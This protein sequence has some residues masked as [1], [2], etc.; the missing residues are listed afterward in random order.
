[1]IEYKE[2]VANLDKEKVDLLAYRVTTQ[3]H[4]TSCTTKEFSRA[5]PKL[6]FKNDEIK[7]LKEILTEKETKIHSLNEV[8]ASKETTIIE[9]ENPKKEVEVKYSKARSRTVGK[10]LHTREKHILW[11]K[12]SVEVTKLR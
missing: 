9:I 1:M 10:A 12:L 8:V 4:S 7:A 3:Q 2:K 6:S 5:M 11:D